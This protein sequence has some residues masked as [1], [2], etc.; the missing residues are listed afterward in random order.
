MESEETEGCVHVSRLQVIDSLIVMN[1]P[2]AVFADGDNKLR[3]SFQFMFESI[4][5]KAWFCYLKVFHQVRVV[6]STEEKAKIAFQQLDG[7]FFMNEKLKL[8]QAPEYI[9]MGSS[10]LQVPEPD[11]QFLI[12][13]PSTP[14]VGWHQVREEKPAAPQIEDILEALHL[15]SADPL[16]PFQLHAGSDNTP[17]I[18]IHAPDPMEGDDH[19]PC[20]HSHM[21]MSAM[22]AHLVQTARPPLPM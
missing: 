7:A 6:F 16:V 17:S 1:P 21:K 5:P 18:L 11:K 20:H 9:R 12:S 10:T 19:E 2:W 8:R 13:P 22:P 15:T 4:D 14:P 3:S